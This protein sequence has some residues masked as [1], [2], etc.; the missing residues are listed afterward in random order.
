MYNSLTCLF[1]PSGARTCASTRLSLQLGPSAAP[2]STA[3]GAPVG[4]WTPFT[5]PFGAGTGLCS[6]AGPTAGSVTLFSDGLGSSVSL[7]PTTNWT[8][9]PRAP[10]VP[11][12][13]DRRAA[14]L[15]ITQVAARAPPTQWIGF[16][17]AGSCIPSISTA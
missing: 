15:L 2:L 16:D 17:L 11:N 3:A 8:V 13:V 1:F 7:N 14:A 9:T 4:P 6:Y 10:V 12:T 5:V